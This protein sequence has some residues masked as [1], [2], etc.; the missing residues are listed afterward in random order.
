MLYNN[1]DWTDYRPDAITGRS[2][3]VGRQCGCLHHNPAL[4]IFYMDMATQHIH[5]IF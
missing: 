2:S 5:Q 4:H 1:I 3:G